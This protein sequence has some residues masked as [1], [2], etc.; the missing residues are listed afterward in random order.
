[1][2]AEELQFQYEKFVELAKQASNDEDRI[3]RTKIANNYLQMWTDAVAKETAEREEKIKNKI[4]AK[5][6]DYEEWLKWAESLYSINKEGNKVFL[7]SNARDWKE[8]REWDFN[9]EIDAKEKRLQLVGWK[10]H[11]RNRGRGD[12]SKDLSKLDKALAVTDS[13]PD[14]WFGK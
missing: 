12:M 13:L 14:T 8:D 4:I 10:I 7:R 1:M 5:G 9:F 2:D 6:V 11:D 3:L